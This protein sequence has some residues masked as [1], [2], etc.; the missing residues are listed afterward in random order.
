MEEDL[1]GKPKAKGLREGLRSGVSKISEVFTPRFTMAGK[2][3]DS[4]LPILTEP[5]KRK[6]LKGPN[7]ISKP[8]IPVHTNNR[9][10][11]KQLVNPKSADKGTND[12]S[13]GAEIE[14]H[15][16]T[17]LIDSSLALEN[18]LKALERE[19]SVDEGKDNEIATENGLDREK[20]P[21][22]KEPENEKVNAEG[23]GSTP[24]VIV[25]QVEVHHDDKHKDNQI[26]IKHATDDGDLIEKETEIEMKNDSKVRQLAEIE[27]IG[28]I[29]GSPSKQS[30]DIESNEAEPSTLPNP[31]IESLKN[32]SLTGSACESPCCSPNRIQA[33]QLEENRNKTALRLELNTSLGLDE[34]RHKSRGSA[35]L[36]PPYV[37]PN[38]EIESSIDN[39]MQNKDKAPAKTPEPIDKI[40]ETEID[41]NEQIEEYDDGGELETDYPDSQE[42]SLTEDQYDDPGKD[43]LQ[44]HENIE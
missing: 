11:N 12:G 10:Q 37:T 32:T 39:S 20:L 6:G 36:E 31:I 28:K 7:P 40:D 35:K 3:K 26:E 5:L 42:D 19:I 23:S 33:K 30:N 24:E 29:Q 1:Q 13:G 27:N 43:E 2:G 34:S 16:E 8:K 4:N 25:T 21:P 18:S 9:E 14:K 22:L 38:S 17:N 41:P 44:P 15:N